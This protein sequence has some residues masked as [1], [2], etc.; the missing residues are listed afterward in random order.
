MNDKYYEQFWTCSACGKTGISLLRNQKCT[1]CGHAFDQHTDS[2]QRSN[3]EIT[4]Q[5]GLELAMGGPHWVCSSCGSRN[6]DK[7]DECPSCANE[8][9]NSDD[10]IKIQEVSLNAPNYHPPESALDE[11]IQWVGIEEPDIEEEFPIG[12]QNPIEAD[13]SVPDTATTD[14][15]SVF[16]SRI[17]NIPSR[18]RYAG[19]IGIVVLLGFLGY[20]F[21]QTKEVSAEAVSFSWERTIS[22]ERYTTVHESGW[23]RPA[24]AY[25]VTSTRKVSRYESIYETKTRREYHSKTCRQ[26]LGNG[27]ERTYECGSYEYETYREK[28]GEKPIYDDWYEY[29]IDKWTSV[30]ERKSSGKDQHPY[31]PSYTLANEGSNS[32]GSERVGSRSETYSIHFVSVDKDHKKYEYHA[33]ESDWYKYELGRIY[34]LKVNHFSQI[35]NNPLKENSD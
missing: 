7:Y 22:I 3:V 34:T 15:T 25:N 17:N 26:D 9:D 28:V 30:R 14:Y 29:D 6:L 20:L 35:R 18:V 5:D 10:F 33:K 23:T 31:W 1:A 2:K 16:S 27:A 11:I 21:F 13:I 19:I 32:L 4:D 24:G 12:Y 8:A